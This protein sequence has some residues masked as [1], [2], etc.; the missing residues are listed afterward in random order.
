MSFQ[1]QMVGTGSAFG[2]KYYNN[3]A[4]IYTNGYTLMIDFGYTATAAL[5]SMNKDLDEIDGILITHLHA[6]HIGGLEELAF[7]MNYNYKKKPDLYVPSILVG[8][9]WDHALKA[10]LENKV[11]DMGRLQSYFNVI[12]LEEKKKHNIHNELSV[13]TI[14]TKHIPG[15]PSYSLIIND[16]FFYS[17]DIQF[18]KELLDYIHN[19]RKCTTLFHDCQL[20]NPGIVHATLDQLLTLPKEVQKKIYLMHYEDDM[21]RYIGKTGHMTFLEQHKIYE[22]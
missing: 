14:S 21:E 6:D 13:E 1:V 22:F 15:K 3:S 12:P 8:P 4:L 16:S 18:S 11:E 7:R 20:V 2:K 9:L 19:D 17:A 10:G 5:H